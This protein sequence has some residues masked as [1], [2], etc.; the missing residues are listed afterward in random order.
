MMMLRLAALLMKGSIAWQGASI[1]LRWHMKRKPKIPLTRGE[2]RV[3]HDVPPNAVELL[4]GDRKNE[5]LSVLVVG[6]SVTIDA[7]T[8][9]AMAPGLW[10]TLWKI[11]VDGAVRLSPGP[12]IKVKLSA[13]DQRD[14]LMDDVKDDVKKAVREIDWRELVNTVGPSLVS[15]AIAYFRERGEPP[16]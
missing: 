9:K 11:E 14:S 10:H 5:G 8:S 13:I 4:M 12:K 2:T 16:S 1:A 3:V 15:A 7:S 6:G